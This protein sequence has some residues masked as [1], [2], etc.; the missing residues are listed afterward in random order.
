MHNA[1][2]LRREGTNKTPRKRKYVHRLARPFN[3][4]T[5]CAARAAQVLPSRKD[6]GSHVHCSLRAGP[7]THRLRHLR[8]SAPGVDPTPRPP[9]PD[10]ETHPTRQQRQP[11]RRPPPPART[12][13]VV[14]ANVERRGRHR[15]RGVLVGR[16]GEW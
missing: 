12:G 1:C 4:P 8:T 2:P 16:G 9:A 15:G 13:L 10:G 3:L 7:C 5:P 14:L 11:P 6:G